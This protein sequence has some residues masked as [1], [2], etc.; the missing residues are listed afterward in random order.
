MPICANIGNAACDALAKVKASAGDFT[1][2]N[3]GDIAF[4]CK[5]E[6]A[7]LEDMGSGA[8][9]KGAKLDVT[10]SAGRLARSISSSTRMVTA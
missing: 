8:D 5:K 9:L 4:F 3:K 6:K 7:I 1:A 10:P 2:M